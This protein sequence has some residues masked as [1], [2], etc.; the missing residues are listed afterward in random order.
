MLVVPDEIR[1]LRELSLFSGVGGGVLA[2]HLL[3]WKTL[4]YVEWDDFCGK[5]LTARIKDGVLP[6]APIHK[7]VQDFDGTVWRGKVDVV[8][9]GFPCFIAGTLILTR[10]GYR[11]IEEIHVGDEVLTHRGRWRPVTSLMCKM[12]APVRKIRAQGVPGVVGTDEHPFYARECRRVWA[13]KPRGYTRSFGEADWVGASDLQVHVPGTPPSRQRTHFVGQV[14]PPSKPDEHT[15]EFWWLIGRYL[16][17]GWRVRRKDRPEGNGRVVIS[18]HHNEADALEPRIKAA[19]FHATRSREKSATKMHIVRKDLY[20]FT[21]AFG[22]YAHGKRLPGFVLELETDKAR[23]LVDGYFSGDGYREEHPKKGLPYQRATSTSRALALG[24]ALLVQR[25]HGVVVSVR[26]VK[27]KPKAVIEGREVNQ[28]DWYAVQIP[29]RNRSAF[30][31]GAYGW[32]LVRKNEPCGKAAVYN[33]AVKEDESY[34]AEGA[35]VHNCQPFSVAGKKEGEN[36]ERN[37][38]PATIH[39]IREVRPRYAFLENVPGLLA[40]RHGYFGTVLRQLAESG[41]DAVW[42]CVSAASVGAPHRRERL[43]VLAHTQDFG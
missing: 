7:D 8:S 5:V 2:T 6:D 25:S 11:P 36:D 10:D 16:A 9:A 35:V 30:V 41:Y 38:W 34:M 27:T 14:L 42:D 32:K 29:S 39:V 22:K 28:R 33:L 23:A 1:G 18:C 13:T 37:M 17:D 43:W 21:E 12:E 4:A 26:R 15:P 3:G 19:G 24:M 31:E 20:A 40:G